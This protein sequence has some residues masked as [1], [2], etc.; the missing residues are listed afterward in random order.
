M[1][2]EYL[3]PAIEITYEMLLRNN[4]LP[5]A[6][7][8]LDNAELEISYKSCIAIQFAS[9]LTD[10]SAFIETSHHLLKLSLNYAGN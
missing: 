3:G 4:Q 10:I 2:T 1:E 8:S 6:P 5:E 7:A 9:R